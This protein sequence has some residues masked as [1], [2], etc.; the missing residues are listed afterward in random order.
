MQYKNLLLYFI[1]F[2]FS[3]L[4]SNSQGIIKTQ[5][6]GL[7]IGINGDYKFKNNYK[8]LFSQ[9]VR[10]FE[11]VSELEKSI[12]EIG[13]AYK[14][15]KNFKLQGNLRYVFDKKKNKIFE[16]NLR[17]NIDLRYKWDINKRFDFKYRLRF[18]TRYNNFLLVNKN[19]T[20]SDFRH[21]I[22]LDYKLNKKHE[23]NLSGEIWR[24]FEQYELPHFGKFRFVFSDEIDTKIGDFNLF[25]GLERDIDSKPNLNYYITGISY[26]FSI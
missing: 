5:D 13:L 26:N 18:Q 9:E 1:L 21:K 22:T 24:E 3:C 11:S 12:S 2:A 6:L 16:K 4:F 15:N 19:G 10:F 23:L 20:K 8:L 17:Y 25:F 14:I 7:W